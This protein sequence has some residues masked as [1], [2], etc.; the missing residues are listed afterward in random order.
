MSSSLNNERRIQKELE[1]ICQISIE[2]TGR[3]LQIDSEL[4]V[5]IDDCKKAIDELEGNEDR[6]G[7]PTDEEW[8]RQYMDGKLDPRNI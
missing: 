2:M 6:Y 7:L 3:L 1:S 4:R 8:Q 5:A